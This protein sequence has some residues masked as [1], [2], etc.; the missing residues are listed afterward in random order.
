MPGLRQALLPFGPW[1]F[2]RSL[3]PPRRRW[4]VEHNI[5][6]PELDQ[7]VVGLGLE[8]SFPQTLRTERPCARAAFGHVHTVNLGRQVGAES[9]PIPCM[10]SLR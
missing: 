6:M 1:T 8:R 2:G 7:H 5:V 9:A 4:P 3:A 10:V